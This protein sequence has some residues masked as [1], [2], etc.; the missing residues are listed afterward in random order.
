MLPRSLKIGAHIY[1][2]KQA[3]GKELGEDTFSDVSSETNL[4]RISKAATRSR[5]IELILH[6][7]LHAMLAGHEFKAEETVI[8]VLG[9]ALTQFLADN[10]RFI[11]EALTILSDPKK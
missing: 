11:R 4:I 2:L 7:T 6:E 9:E 1:K 5:K 8:V 3:D 10:P